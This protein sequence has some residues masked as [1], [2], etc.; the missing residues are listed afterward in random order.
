MVLIFNKFYL[1]LYL[2]Q[3]NL[4]LSKIKHMPIIANE[5]RI[6]SNEEKNL[7]TC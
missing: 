5:I 4:R 1:Y 2:I 6:L 7:K 3:K